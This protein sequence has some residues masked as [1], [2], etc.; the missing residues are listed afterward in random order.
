MLT[1]PRQ[2]RDKR[3][4]KLRTRSV[5]GRQ[6]A[7]RFGND[8]DRPAIPDLFFEWFPYVCPEPVLVKCSF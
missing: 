5:F 2:A 8:N 7:V 1:L 6:P 4:G 3:R